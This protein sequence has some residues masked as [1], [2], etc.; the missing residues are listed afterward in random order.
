MRLRSTPS[1]AGTY[2]IPPKA[3]V[4]ASPLTPPAAA[5]HKTAVKGRSV[6]QIFGSPDDLKF[7][8]SMRLFA[9]ATADNQIF[10]EAL[11]LFFEGEEDRLTL[12]A[13]R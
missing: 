1:S 11:K 13:A 5:L 3:T 9:Y 6:R 7:R 10:V 4:I 8:S 2:Q 12:D